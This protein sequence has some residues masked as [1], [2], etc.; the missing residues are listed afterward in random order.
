[1]SKMARQLVGEGSNRGIARHHAGSIPATATK[2]RSVVVLIAVTLNF[3]VEV[4][5][6]YGIG[7]YVL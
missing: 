6:S 1:M 4:T 2:P 3:A 7:V 5:R